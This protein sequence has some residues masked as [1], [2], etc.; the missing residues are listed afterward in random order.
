M[1]K[2]SRL[3]LLIVGAVVLPGS[4]AYGQRVAS[5]VGTVV[6]KEDL[7]R[8][9]V[10]RDVTEREGVISGVLINASDDVLTQ[11]RLLIDYQWLWANEFRPG[12]DS[13]ARAY[14][15]TL[16]GEIPPRGSAPFSFQLPTPLPERTDGRFNP[17]VEVLGL[18]RY[19]SAGAPSLG[20]R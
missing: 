7:S 10:V 8:V 12:D 2:H 14:F 18:V 16:P 17:S 9:L 19:E 6:S 5:P 1:N 3:A 20:S 15:Y 4:L 13:P 11:V